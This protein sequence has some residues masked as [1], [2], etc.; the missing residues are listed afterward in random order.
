MYEIIS[1]VVGPLCPIYTI[2]IYNNVDTFL[3]RASSNYKDVARKIA[4]NKIE[5]MRS[6]GTLPLSHTFYS[7]QLK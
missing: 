7:I 2:E 5:K 4:L 1:K 6:H 3:A